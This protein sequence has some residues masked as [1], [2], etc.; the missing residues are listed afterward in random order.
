[1][2]CGCSEQLKIAVKKGH[3]SVDG[4]SEPETWARVRFKFHIS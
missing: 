3:L 2:I 4:V 1:M